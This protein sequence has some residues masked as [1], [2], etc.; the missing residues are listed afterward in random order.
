[1]SNFIQQSKG[2]DAN[3]VKISDSEMFY[4][5]IKYDGVYI[6]IHKSGDVVQ[7]FTSSGKE[8]DCSLSSEFKKFDFDFII[9]TE[10]IV[11]GGKLGA[12]AKANSEIKKS[13]KNPSFSLTGEFKIHD[14]L[15]FNNS[16]NFDYDFRLRLQHFSN[17]FDGMFIENTLMKYSDAKDILKKCVENNEEGLFLK[18]PTHK[19]IVGKKTN[20]AIKLKNKLTADLCVSNINGLNV[21]LV[22]ENGLV[23]KIV[24]SSQISNM[25]EIGYIVEIEYEQIIH[26]Y[27]QAVFKD[28]RFDKMNRSA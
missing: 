11:D 28:I 26:T 9:E 21:E 17:S 27:N 10:Y 19:H 13:I 3:K 6:Q 24:A 15:D 2:F 18:K 8:F 23:A 7:F 12:R 5:S 20:G 22:D 14:V 25:L 1:M 16:D 4:V